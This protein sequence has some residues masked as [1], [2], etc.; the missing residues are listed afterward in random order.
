MTAPRIRLSGHIDVPHERRAAVA[1]AL[2]EHVR[3]TRA[4]PGCLRFEV[5][6]DPRHYRIEEVA[7]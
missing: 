5:T 6:P 2:P 7:P 1:E 4:E 3:L